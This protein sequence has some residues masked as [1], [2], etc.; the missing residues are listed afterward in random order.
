MFEGDKAVRHFKLRDEDGLEL[1]NAI[2][3]IFV[4]LPK[5]DAALDKPMGEMTGMEMWGLYFSYADKLE[6]SE[7]VNEKSYIDKCR[8]DGADRNSRLRIPA[9]MAGNT[10]FGHVHDCFRR[11][12]HVLQR[13]VVWSRFVAGFQ[14]VITTGR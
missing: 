1:T 6:R 10:C 8:A 3:E 4:Q 13:L 2:N 14:T 5:F 12:T 9:K 11:S 7:A